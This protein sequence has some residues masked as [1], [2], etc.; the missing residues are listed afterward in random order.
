MLVLEGRHAEWT[1]ARQRQTLYALPY[2]LDP[3][4]KETRPE[5][6]G[7]VTHTVFVALFKKLRKQID[8]DYIPPKC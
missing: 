6:I 8:R 7:F 3:E 5:C 4:F 2:P 1:K